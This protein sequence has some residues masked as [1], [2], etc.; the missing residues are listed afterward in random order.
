[1]A[2]NEFDPNS[3]INPILGFKHSKYACPESDD[4]DITIVKRV[5]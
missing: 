2:S 3:G 4:I 1:M 5:P